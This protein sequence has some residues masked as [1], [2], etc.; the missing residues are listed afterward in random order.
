MKLQQKIAFCLCE[1][2]T[3][4][5]VRKSAERFCLFGGQR[6]KDAGSF[7]LVQRQLSSA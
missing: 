7:A 1:V 3:A 6:E 4:H 2:Y 5:V